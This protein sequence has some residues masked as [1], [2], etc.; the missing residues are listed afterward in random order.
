[1][2]TGRREYELKV[3][4]AADVKKS[5]TGTSYSVI[6]AGMPDKTVYSMVVTRGS[7]YQ[8]IAYNLFLPL[9]ERRVSLPIG[10]LDVSD[11]SA[12][13]ICFGFVKG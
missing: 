2:A 13:E 4:E 11:V 9:E 10:Y 12:G 3:G 8:A 6:Y 1:M 5:F 7:G